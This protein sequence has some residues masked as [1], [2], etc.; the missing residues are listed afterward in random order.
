MLV[1]SCDQNGSVGSP[2]VV[3]LI[4]NTE[5]AHKRLVVFKDFQG[6]LKA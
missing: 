6:L 3:G 4:Y 2:Y 1:A 5:N